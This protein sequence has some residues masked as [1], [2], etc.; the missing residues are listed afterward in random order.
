[1]S[2][3][4]YRRLL[5]D[6]K[7]RINEITIENYMKSTAT[8]DKPLLIDI[9]ET[10][11]WAAGH[12]PEALHISRGVLEGS[13]EEEVPD[14]TTPIVLSCA[15]GNRS[16]LSAESLQK[17]GYTRVSSLI[18]GFAAWTQAGLPVVK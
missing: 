5:A 1:M 13:I 2:N 9:R 8:A 11:E 10:G 17:M 16:A 12:A 14:V 18:G 4:R 7:T 15:G 3:D 6:V